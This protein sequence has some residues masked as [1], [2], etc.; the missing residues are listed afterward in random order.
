LIGGRG[1]NDTITGGARDVLI[2]GAGADIFR[3]FDI[4]E[5]RI[6]A[7]DVIRDFFAGVDRID[8]SA[9][10]TAAGGVDRAFNFIGEGQLTNAG[11]MHAR[12]SGGNAIVAGDDRRP[13]GRLRDHAARHP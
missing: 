3:Y 10:D 1:G 13:C 4:G 12:L 5:T 11:D 6:G 7:G 2:G 8:L 9:I